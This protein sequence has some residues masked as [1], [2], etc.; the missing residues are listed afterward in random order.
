M[1]RSEDSDFG[2]LDAIAHDF[3]EAISKRDPQLLKAAL[4]N[5][6]EHLKEEDEFQDQEQFNRGF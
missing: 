2:F 3:L 4:E 6:K 1:H 5:F